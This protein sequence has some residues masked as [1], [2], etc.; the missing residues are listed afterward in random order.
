MDTKRKMGER[1]AKL[2]RSRAARLPAK[3]PIV[4]VARPFMESP[5]ADVDES[6]CDD[7]V[8]PEE[9]SYLQTHAFDAIEEGDDPDCAH[10]FDSPTMINIS[11]EELRRL[12]SYE[13]VAAKQ[14]ISQR[15]SRRRPQ[16]PQIF[17]IRQPP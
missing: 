14:V 13:D 5:V 17:I 15:R 7:P 6:S 3:I 2:S 4:D 16:G 10:V 9:Q 11:R 1:Q 12:A 8:S